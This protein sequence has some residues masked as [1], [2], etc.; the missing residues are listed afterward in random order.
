MSLRGKKKLGLSPLFKNN[1]NNGSVKKING[2][3]MI[4]ICVRKKENNFRNKNISYKWIILFYRN[5]Q[6]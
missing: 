5:S 6:W 2:N 3:N 4:R 1:N